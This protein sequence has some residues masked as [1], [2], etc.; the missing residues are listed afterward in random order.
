MKNLSRFLVFALLAAAC[1]DD[2]APLGGNGATGGGGGSGGEPPATGGDSAGGGAP[3]VDAQAYCEEVG[4]HDEECVVAGASTTA[5]CLQS[6]ATQCIFGG[7]RPETR[8]AIVAC[9]FDRP[10]EDDPTLLYDCVYETGGQVATVPQQGQFEQECVNTLFMCGNFEDVI[11]SLNF[12]D[13]AAYGELRACLDG[14]DCFA[15]SDCLDAALAK[16]CPG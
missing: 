16:L 9:V 10:C 2:S 15:T 13:D 14:E 3:A 8:D 1:G 11:C 6:L 5:G 12:F 7:A 4:T